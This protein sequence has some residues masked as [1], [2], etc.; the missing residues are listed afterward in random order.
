M[1]KF[2]TGIKDLVTILS[3][4]AT[5]GLGY[6]GKLQ[7]DEAKRA[8]NNLHSTTIQYEDEKGRLVTEVTEL[9]FTTKELK[10]IAKQDSAKLSS[11]QKKL[12]KAHG[13]ITELNIKERNAESINIADL[14]VFNDSLVTTAEYDKKGLLKALKP[15]KTDNLEIS[16][17]VLSD[18]VVVNHKYKTEITTIVK[19]EADKTTKNG[20]KRFFLARWVNPRWQYSAINVSDDKKA[21]IA[22]AIHIKFQ[23]GKGDR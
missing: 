22:S 18:T 1:F 14:S 4:L 6:W 15:I 11:V 17:N 9:R 10:Q 20:K 8:I 19:R 5:V 7:K 13:K 16:F 12:L 23:R 3:I 21:K 2:I